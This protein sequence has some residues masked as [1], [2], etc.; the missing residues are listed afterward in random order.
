M[1]K[2]I[3]LCLITICF[4]CSSDSEEEEV[5]PVIRPIVDMQYIYGDIEGK[6]L[7]LENIIYAPRESLNTGIFVDEFHE[8]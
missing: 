8:N 5:E 1:K 6:Q 2:I 7:N 3:L 4:S